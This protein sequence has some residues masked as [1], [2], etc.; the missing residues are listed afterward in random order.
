MKQVYLLVAGGLCCSGQ[1]HRLTGSCKALV[2]AMCGCCRGW[3]GGFLPPGCLQGLCL[4]LPVLV[5]SV[6]CSQR[7]CALLLHCS[8]LPGGLHL[9]C[10]C[11]AHCAT[12][13][14][15]PQWRALSRFGRGGGVAALRLPH[16]GELPLLLAGCALCMS[17]PGVGCCI[18]SG[19]FGWCI[20][21]AS[22]CLG[23]R[24][25]HGCKTNQDLKRR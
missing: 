19:R 20:M 8:N 23:V 24:A 5:D 12:S 3:G 13:N 11:L 10:I 6:G 21:E 17:C 2:L 7:H 9:C 22:L 14:L 16:I 4:E 18:R 25:R 1:M 15:L